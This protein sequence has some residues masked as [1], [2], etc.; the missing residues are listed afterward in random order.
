MVKKPKTVKKVVKKVAKQPVRK[1][2]PPVVVKPAPVV[3]P[4]VVPPKVEIVKV[5]DTKKTALLEKLRVLKTQKAN[6]H[7][8]RMEQLYELAAMIDK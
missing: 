3:A 6:G 8:I 2:P 1:L 5:E 7:E 4:V